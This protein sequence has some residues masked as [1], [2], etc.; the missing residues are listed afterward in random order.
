VLASLARYHKGGRPKNSHENW[1]RLN[2]YLQAVVEKLAAIL[3][4]AD[5]LDRSHRQVV[6]SASCRVRSRKIELEVSARADCE[7]ELDAA[8][9]KADLFERVFDR[10]VALRAVPVGHAGEVHQKDLEILSAEALWN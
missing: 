6:A 9:K 7:P 2:P 4:I 1:R 8:R 5:G 3:R 10:G